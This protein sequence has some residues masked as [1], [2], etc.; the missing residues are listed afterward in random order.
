MELVYNIPGKCSGTKLYSIAIHNIIQR[1]KRF[2][3]EGAFFFAFFN[4]IPRNRNGWMFLI[5]KFGPTQIAVTNGNFNLKTLRMKQEKKIIASL[6]CMFILTLFSC[7]E[8]IYNGALV[9]NN[10]PDRVAIM[11]I[12]VDDVIA[13][14]ENPEIKKFTFDNFNNKA[15]LV[16]R[17]EQPDSITYVY[18]EKI[19]K[20]GEYTIYSFKVNEFSKDNRNELTYIIQKDARSGE[21]R[22]GFI[23]FT[24]DAGI[25]ELNFT[26]FNGTVEVLNINKETVA[27]DKF[28]QGTK[29]VTDEASRGIACTDHLDLIVH[30]CTAGGEHTPGDGLE[31]ESNDAYWEVAVHTICTHTGGAIDSPGQGAAPIGG[32]GGSITP[33]I[34][35]NDITRCLTKKML[36]DVF[37]NA[38][39]DTKT[40]LLNVIRNYAYL[41]DI[42]TK[43][44][45]CQFLGQAAGE[46]DGFTT[47]N[48]T[49][50]LNYTTS[51]RLRKTFRGKF[52]LTNPNLPNGDDYLNNPEKLANYVYS[53]IIGN[54]SVAS[55]DGWKYRGRGVLQLTGKANYQ[56]FGNYMTNI[57][58]G[59]WYNNDPNNLT[60]ADG[61]M[62]I[63]SGMWYFKTRVLN[64]MEVNENT[65]VKKVT[66]EVSPGSN[67]LQKRTKYY[68]AAKL[69]INCVTLSS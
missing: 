45:L 48:A 9:Q 47:L 53:G 58:L 12:N 66:R 68:N 52:S 37:P 38:T 42:N 5:I 15:T 26:A 49:E 11:A 57:G 20:N 67:S 60:N 43:E 33:P 21:E 61:I 22:A 55:G 17:A 51:A 34:I 25:D 56:A 46:T 23:R 31:C 13:E 50:D 19:I 69:K 2:P 6:I 1:K 10:Q 16:Q 35:K 24:P 7:S 63:L 14:L 36:N 3:V 29:L 4:N 44:E 27:I 40:K 30:E 18:F 65:P 54:G 64:K 62:A 39:D 59:W 28:T 41:F 8:E 32:G